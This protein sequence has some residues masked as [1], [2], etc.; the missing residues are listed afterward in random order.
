MKNKLLIAAAFLAGFALKAF[1]QSIRMVYW[2]HRAP[3]PANIIIYGLRDDGVVVWR[4]EPCVTPDCYFSG[5]VHDASR[6]DN[7]ATVP[8]II[9]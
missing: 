8:D 7:S 2:S 9:P 3:V 5:Q 4:K 1:A 6:P